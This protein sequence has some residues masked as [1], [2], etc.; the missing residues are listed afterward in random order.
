L[1]CLAT[2]HMT[3]FTILCSQIWTF[4]YYFFFILIMLNLALEVILF[5]KL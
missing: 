4:L 5:K 1:S 3:Y 2:F